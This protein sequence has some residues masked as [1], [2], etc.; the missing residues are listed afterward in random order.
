VKTLYIERS[1][2]ECR[3]GAWVE[4]LDLDG[5]E[6]IIVGTGPGSF[7]GIRS[8]IAF[9]QGY[10]AA[11]SC[12]VLGLESVCAIAAQENTGGPLV[13]L[14]DAR[15]GKFWVALFDGLKMIGKVFQVD[16]EGLTKRVPR[17]VKI[18]SPDEGRIG[19]ILK[20]EFGDF[21]K[22]LSLPT[23]N[24]LKLYAEAMPDSLASD[25]LPIYL[26]PAVRT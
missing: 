19:K 13:V 11:G 20:D 24:G 3:S 25:P 18:V 17:G 9:A 1:T 7:A 12:E 21:Y 6:R 22:G 4:E 10:A 16:R 23:A 2:G 14:G 5:V 15:Q 8:A 26:N